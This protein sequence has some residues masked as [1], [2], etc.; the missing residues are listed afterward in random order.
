M[1]NLDFSDLPIDPDFA[2]SF[3]VLRSNGSFVAG[4][5]TEGTPLEIPM[6]GTIYPSTQR[7]IQ[8][9]P[10]GD[11]VTGMT[12]F[13]ATQ[14]IYTTHVSS[15]QGICDR[16]TWHGDSYGIISVFDYSDFGGVYVA[17]GT[18]LTGA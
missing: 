10:E 8:Q 13:V 14:P 9:V 5:W 18:M 12:T 11:R 4:L 1:P 6:Y 3:T 7:E 16:I 17:V 2:Q 15:T